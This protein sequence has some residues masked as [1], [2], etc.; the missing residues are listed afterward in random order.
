[1]TRDKLLASCALI[2]ERGLGLRRGAAMPLGQLFRALHADVPVDRAT[3]VVYTVPQD[4]PRR[5][6]WCALE[7]LVQGRPPR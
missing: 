1:M 2:T 6:L 4:D 7:L 3:W 5:A